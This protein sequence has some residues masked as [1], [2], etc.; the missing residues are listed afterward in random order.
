MKLKYK[1]TSEFRATICGIEVDNQ[2]IYEIAWNILEFIKLC[3]NDI[4]DFKISFVVD[5]IKA[6][7]VSSLYYD[8]DT[9]LEEILKSMSFDEET[10][11]LEFGGDCS[12]T[13]IQ[14]LGFKPLEGYYDDKE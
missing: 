10:G 8:L 13:Y 6:L 2:E 14:G 5:L 12:S 11:T 1:V 7:K 4:F 9:L 3:S